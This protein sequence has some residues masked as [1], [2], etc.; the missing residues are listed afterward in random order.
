MLAGAVL[1]AL[2]YPWVE[3][4]IQ[5]VGALGNIR[6]PQ[7]TGIPEWGWFV[8]LIVIAGMVFWLLE[9]TFSKNA[10]AELNNSRT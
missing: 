9:T 2:S 3:A 4:H 10:R 1:Y 8:I 5:T 6:L 7:L